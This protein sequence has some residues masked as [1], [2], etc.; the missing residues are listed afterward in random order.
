MGELVSNAMRGSPRGSPGNIMIY[1]DYILIKTY[2][3]VVP[4]IFLVKTTLIFKFYSYIGNY[5][6]TT[7][8]FEAYG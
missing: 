1:V 6:E 4:M 5:P 8:P 7:Y 3:N 2:L